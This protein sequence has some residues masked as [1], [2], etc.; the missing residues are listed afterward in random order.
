MSV[1][2]GKYYVYF[3]GK[4]GNWIMSSFFISFNFCGNQGM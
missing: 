1:W 4:G 2:M 3:K